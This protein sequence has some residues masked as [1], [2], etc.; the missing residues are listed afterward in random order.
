MSV[1]RAALAGLVALLGCAGEPRRGASATGGGAATTDA[2]ADADA[3]LPVPSLD[4]IAAAAQH[5]VSGMR[6]LVR[7]DHVEG[8]SPSLVADAGAGTCVRARFAASRAVDVALVDGEGRARGEGGHGTGGLVPPLGPA[9]VTG[10]D[11]LHLVV[12]GSP[13]TRVRAVVLAAP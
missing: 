7:L 10:G 13:G 1:R 4:E 3:G 5:D 11:G 8:R 9:C 12:R 2:G 6:E